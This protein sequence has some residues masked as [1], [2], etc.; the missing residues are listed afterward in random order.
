MSE[1]IVMPVVPPTDDYLYTV[2][3]ASKILRVNNNAV[4]SLIK[5]GHLS[6][7][8]LGLIK[9]RKKELESFMER[10]DGMDLSDLDDVK[11]LEW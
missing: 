5:K 9:I 7:I 1:K 4:Y 10:I 8:K 6:A 2:S 3:E 11:K